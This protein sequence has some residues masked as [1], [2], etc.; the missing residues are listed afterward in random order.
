MNIRNAT[1]NDLNQMMTIFSNARKFMAENGNKDQWGK[2]NW[3][4][5]SLII[6][7]IENKKSYV[8][9]DDNDKVLGTFF[10]D[11][12]YKVEPAYNKIE[13][14]KWKGDETY[15]VVHRIASDNIT[16]GVGTFCIKYAMEKSK[17]LR[18]D[19]HED[20][21]PMQNLLNKLGFKKC[22]T[23]YVLNG[24]ELRVAFEWVQVV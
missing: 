8:C 3:P 5:E 14:G 11:Y 18:I 7:D 24:T 17:H 19:T 9:V 12:G 6:N 13:N 16:K 23:I 4:P 21:K 10:Y 20:N 15:G 22:G 1:M 2:N